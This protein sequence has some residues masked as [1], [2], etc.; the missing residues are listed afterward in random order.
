MTEKIRAF[1][2]K[3]KWLL[4]CGCAVLCLA[5]VLLR[6]NRPGRFLPVHLYLL[7]LF[8][9]AFRPSSRIFGILENHSQWKQRLCTVLVLLVTIAACIYPMG[10]DPAWNGEIWD[11]Y[12]Y[13]LLT[14][15]FLDGRLDIPFNDS[16]ELSQLENPYDPILREESGVTFHWDF[17]YY[18]DQYYVYFG[19]VPVLLT[20]LPYQL[21]TGD[22]K[23][24]V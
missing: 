24:V 18:N 9:Y 3:Y 22:R 1:A 20:F 21:L 4:L 7:G 8:L 23:S 13:E 6:W 5:L 12:Q 16:Q 11:H 2:I 10:V 15:S 17:A 19:V 14:E